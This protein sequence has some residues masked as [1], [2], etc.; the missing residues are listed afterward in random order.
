[1][2]SVLSQEQPALDYVWEQITQYT[3]RNLTSPS[4]ILDGV[5]G[6]L[7]IF[8]TATPACR[9]FWGVPIPPPLPAALYYDSSIFERHPSDSLA[10]FA[11]TTEAGFVGCL[12]W[13]LEQPA[14]RRHGFPSWSWTGWIGTAKMRS[15]SGDLIRSCHIFRDVTINVE[16]RDGRM[17]R[18]GE[19]LESY[20]QLN[21]SETSQFIQLSAWATPLKLLTS[22]NGQDVG[23]L[24]LADGRYMQ[25]RFTRTAKDPL[26]VQKSYYAVWLWLGED[27]WITRL[28]HTGLDI[29]VVMETGD[30][31]STVERVG[32]GGIWNSSCTFFEADGTEK[33]SISGPSMVRDR[34]AT[35]EL[36]WSRGVWLEGPGMFPKARR[37]FCIG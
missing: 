28:D 13:E 12:C 26:P 5:L 9:F 11:T 2:Y 7:G 24:D 32:L 37:I 6:I 23:R 20:S 17:V 16:L 1:M 15:Y 25:W 30:E 19:F 10:E 27:R 3:K 21:L 34:D 14:N 36:N 8:E 35:P 29:L 18:W 33:K 22:G 31:R 4:D